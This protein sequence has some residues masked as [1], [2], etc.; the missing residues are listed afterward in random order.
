MGWF[1]F[2]QDPNFINASNALLSMGAG[3]GQAAMPS[4]MPV[5]LAAALGAGAQGLQ[6]GMQ[7]NISNETARMGNAGTKMDL[8]SKLR[9]YNMLAP[10][11]NYAPVDMKSLGLPSAE[12][13]PANP[14][15]SMAAQSGPTPAQAT[16]TG[17]FADMANQPPPSQNAG[18]APPPQSPIAAPS[19]SMPIGGQAECRTIRRSNRLLSKQ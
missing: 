3:F 14:G 12:Q 6:Q 4:R 2:A 8:M 15:S 16:T 11:F 13:G 18:G 5:P 9:Q 17:M 10:I 7:Q 1:D 19:A